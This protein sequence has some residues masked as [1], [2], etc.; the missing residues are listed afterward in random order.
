M[1]KKLYPTERKTSAYTIDYEKMYSKGYRGILFDIDNTLV[2]H[3]A[4][5]DSRAIKLLKRL[6]KIGFTCC[7][8]SNNGETRVAS[9][10]EK[11]GSKYIFDAK[12]PSRSSFQKAMELCGSNQENTIVIGDQ[13]FTDIWGAN[14]VGVHSILVEPMDSK[15]PWTIVLKRKLEKIV[16]SFYERN[17]KKNSK[18]GKGKIRKDSIKKQIRANNL[19]MYK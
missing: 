3:D 16:L 9:F 15:E 6:R 18:E 1:F 19:N 17:R 8:I 11:I 2:P 4:P 5:V 7:F 12:K 13:I 14:K 10:N